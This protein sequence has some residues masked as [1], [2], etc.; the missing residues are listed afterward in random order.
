[1]SAS[2]GPLVSVITPVYNGADFIEECIESILKQSY[3][4]FEYIIVNNCSK[5]ATLAIAQEYARKDSRIKVHDNVDFVGVIENHNNAFKMMSPEAKYCKVCS[6]DDWLYPEC[7]AQMVA[8]AEENPSVGM[9]GSYS[10]AAER[11]LWTGLE[12]ERKVVN[13]RELCRASLLGGP[14]VFG[15]PTSLL[16][17]A[18]LIRESE[19]FYPSRSPHADTSA[20]Y[21]SLEHS[22]FGFVHQV[23]S[24]T[25]IHA[26]SQTSSSLKFGTINRSLIADMARFGPRYLND[27]EFKRELGIRLDKYYA[28]LVHALFEHSMNRDFLQVQKNGLREIGFELKNTRIAKA[29]ASRALEFVQ[30]PNVTGQKITAM[31]KRRGKLTAR[32][33]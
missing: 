15:S 28:W 10:I 17:R 2:A 19:A 32:Y 24:Y 13:G 22:D 9:V 6:A 1:M 27:D 26:D 7:L 12:Y 25:R 29:A 11:I 20:C 8:L 4:N 3:G 16:Y 14:Y 21:E 23:L 31:I 18:D 30:S 5:D 33:Y